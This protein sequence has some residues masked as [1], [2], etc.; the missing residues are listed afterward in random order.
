MLKWR[1]IYP[2]SFHAFV[3]KPTQWSV[4]YITII[5]QNFLVSLMKGDLKWISNPNKPF[6][7]AQW[8]S[9]NPNLWNILLQYKW[10]EGKS[11][12]LVWSFAIKLSR[13]RQLISAKN[14]AHTSLLSRRFSFQHFSFITDGGIVE[15]YVPS[16]SQG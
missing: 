12:P 3:L 5:C 14:A 15:H 13:S 4:S 10:G 9:F 8:A 2:G 7:Q 1:D 11:P 6:V 16:D